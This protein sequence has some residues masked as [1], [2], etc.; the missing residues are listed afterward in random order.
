M[1]SV[2]RGTMTVLLGVPRGSA[3]YYEVL[4]VLLGYE[5]CKRS[6]LSV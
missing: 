4:G 1:R 3:S 6:R 2:A 5:G